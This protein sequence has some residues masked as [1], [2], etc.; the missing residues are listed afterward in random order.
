[1][2]RILMA[3][4]MAVHFVCSS[5]SAQE[6]EYPQEQDG[7]DLALERLL[8]DKGRVKVEIGMTYNASTSDRTTGAFATIRTGT[9]T[10]VSVPVGLG[11]SR[12]EVETLIGTTTVR[13]G[14]TS[15]SELFASGSAIYTHTRTTDGMTGLTTAV[16]DARLLHVVTGVNYQFLEE[17]KRPGLVGFADVTLSENVA[18]TGSEFVFA[19]SGR[20]GL[21]AYK[22][23]DPVVLSLTGGYRPAFSRDVSGTRVDP[24]DVLFLAPFLSFAV[25]NELTLIGGL[26]VRFEGADE[27]GGVTWGAR[28]TRADM[29]FRLAYAWSQDVT[30]LMDAGMD[31]IGE[32]GLI[33]GMSLSRKFYGN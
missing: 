10:F 8:A 5:G 26:S 17:G 25:N 14:L 1:M 9:G 4:V 30:L 6:K 18:F 21:T 19:K 7:I 28:R 29:G 3:V 27:V 22:V 33:V 24:G 20:V 15:R 2:W 13:Y 16:D 11:T 31:A 23:I 32:N 12:R